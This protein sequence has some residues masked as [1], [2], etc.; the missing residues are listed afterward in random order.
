MTTTTT[1]PVSRRRV[2]LTASGAFAGGA[3]IAPPAVAARAP[4]IASGA[5]LSQ[6]LARRL[7][8]IDYI[9]NDPTLDLTTPYGEELSH[10][11]NKIEANLFSAAPQ[12]KVD[13]VV[14]LRFLRTFVEEGYEFDDDCTRLLDAVIAGV[15]Q[16][17]GVA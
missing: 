5:G 17:G 11:L 15:G 2:I 4:T 9:N 14:S 13:I 12:N 8:L 6:L 10:E 3:A 7:A 1:A 16:L